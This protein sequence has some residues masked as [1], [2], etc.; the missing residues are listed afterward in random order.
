MRGAVVATVDAYSGQVTMYATDADDP[1]LR[2]WRGAFPSLFTPAS[3]MPAAVRA[4]LRYP[5][6]LFD[7]Q[8]EVWETYHIDNVDEFYT[9]ADAWQRPAELSGPVQKVGAIR[10]GFGD[11]AG[12][13]PDAPLLPARP[14][15]R[16]APRALH[17][18][19]GVHAPQPGEPERLPD[20]DDGRHAA[21]RASRS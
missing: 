17:A 12:E 2:A 18:H 16:R 11:T 13:P 3:Q 15:A 7:A 9:K 20:R 5:R 10:A 6:E 14:A 4:H 8:S 21:D 1:I 19:D